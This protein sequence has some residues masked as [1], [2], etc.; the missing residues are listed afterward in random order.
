MQELKLP[1]RIQNTLDV[2]VGAL[3]DEFSE[4]LESVIVYGSAAGGEFQRRYSDVNVLVVLK[5]TSLA[6]LKKAAPIVSRRRYRII[7]PLFFTQE[8]IRSSLDVFPIEFLDMKERYAVVYGGDILAGLTI[9]SRNLRFQCEHELRS[10]LIALKRAYLSHPRGFSKDT[11]FAFCTPLVHILRSL[12][13]MSVK[14]APLRQA[15]VL[16]SISAEFAIELSALRAVLEAKENNRRMRHSEA[17][18]LFGTL[19][20]DVE[21]TIELVD[22]L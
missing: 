3:K 20:V 5:D 10:K 22:R 4:E 9:D 6:S 16:G 19:L 11:L 17:E 18:T 15:D 12:L 1:K 13:R 14:E 21:K 7:N 8:Y 2:F